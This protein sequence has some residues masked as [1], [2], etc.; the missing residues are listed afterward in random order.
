[1]PELK[2]ELS[3]ETLIVNYGEVVGGIEDWDILLK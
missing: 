3:N 2:S 1:M